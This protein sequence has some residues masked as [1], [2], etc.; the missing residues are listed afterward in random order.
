M[1]I[2]RRLKKHNNL[3]NLCYEDHFHFPY[4][5]KSN[6]VFINGRKYRFYFPENSSLLKYLCDHVVSKLSD[7]E[8][9]YLSYQQLIDAGFY[10]SYQDVDEN[11]IND[12]AYLRDRLGIFGYEGKEEVLFCSLYSGIWKAKDAEDD[13]WDF[14]KLENEDIENMNHLKIRFYP[15]GLMLF[16]IW[17]R[18]GGY[19]CITKNYDLNG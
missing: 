18:L 10:K 9:A 16:K 2:K 1:K 5:V 6:R 19:D 15:K 4:G 13:F 17:L 14:F 12:F 7:G 3:N 11:V 8:D